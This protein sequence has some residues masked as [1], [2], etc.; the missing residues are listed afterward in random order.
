MYKLCPLNK[1]YFISNCNIISILYALLELH[2]TKFLMCNMYMC[3]PL[4]TKNRELQKGLRNV[5]VQ[6][7]SFSVSLWLLFF[8]LS[9]L[10][11][12]LLF[13]L[14]LLFLLASSLK[15]LLIIFSFLFF[16][17]FPLLFFHLLL[18]FLFFF[19]KHC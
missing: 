16:S 1:F 11:L 9:L 10:F 18:L 17:A 8:L 4:L 19:F 12:S 3:S 15:L 2:V 5:A 7:T 6:Y 13:S 14:F